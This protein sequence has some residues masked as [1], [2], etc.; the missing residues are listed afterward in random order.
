METVENVQTCTQA[1]ALEPCLNPK[2]GETASDTV[3]AEKYNES[4]LTNQLNDSVNPIEASMVV[5]SYHEQTATGS[6]KTKQGMYRCLK[7]QA[8]Q[9]FIVSLATLQRGCAL[10]CATVVKP[11]KTVLVW[12]HYDK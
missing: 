10:W 4:R 2:Y 5:T 11:T 1:N 12:Q 9:G 6:S 3:V 7:S 8:K